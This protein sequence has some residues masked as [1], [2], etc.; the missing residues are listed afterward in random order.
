MVEQKHRLGC[1]MCA[2]SKEPGWLCEEHPDKPWEHHG[3]GGAGMKC[4]CNPMAEVGWGRSMPSGRGTAR[5]SEAQPLHIAAS[6]RIVGKHLHM[7]KPSIEQ[8]RGAI[9]RAA[10]GRRT[11]EQQPMV[12]ELERVTGLRSPSQPSSPRS[13]C[14]SSGWA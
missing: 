10:T 11:A 4:A 13:G 14:R 8:A 5:C 6:L 1:A 3:C 7:S 12:D 2:G 9:E